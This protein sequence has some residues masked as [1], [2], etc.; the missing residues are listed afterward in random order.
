MS[1]TIAQQIAESLQ[2][3]GEEFGIEVGDTIEYDGAEMEVVDYDEQTG[4][5]TL[6]GAD[7]EGIVIS[8]EDMDVEVEV[9][10]EDF[11]AHNAFESAEKDDDE[12]EDDTS[13]ARRIKA[14]WVIRDGKKIKVKARTVKKMKGPQLQALR[15]AARKRK[16]KKLKAGV[17]RARAKSLKLR[18]RVV[19]QPQ[20]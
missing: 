12:E 11:E 20:D 17:L 4:E 7:G 13:E 15:K 3:I 8:I 10:D 5:L 14:G 18:K 6:Q 16:G 19:K 2:S 9:A 1:K